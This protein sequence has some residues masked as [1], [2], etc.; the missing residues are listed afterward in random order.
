[1]NITFVDGS[2]EQYEDTP[3]AFGAEGE[4]FRSK[5]GKYV[6]KLY[7]PDKTLD[8]ERIRRIDTLI[9][10]FNPTKGDPNWADFFTWPEKRVIK[11]T[12]GFRMR[13]V[14]GLKTLEHYILSKAYARLKP[15]ERGWFIGRIATAIKIVS[16]ANRL[17]TMGL[18]YPDFSGKNI[19]VEPFE[20]RM[21]LIDCDSLTVP[22]RLSPT[23][24]GTTSFRAPE[25]VTRAVLV[26]S[27]KTDR[28]ALAVLLYRW[29]LFL[30]PLIGD[31]IF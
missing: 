25:I 20:G 11:P 5:D 19:M 18:C 31:K 2:V 1:M 26:P 28:H 17:A 7:H 4:I 13:Y 21:V 16:A 12:I 9:N 6:V 30:H 14:G 24:E 27:V 29:L 15:E 3:L 8:A 10:D 22:G 23:V